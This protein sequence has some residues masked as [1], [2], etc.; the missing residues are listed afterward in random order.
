M[1]KM[2]GGRRPPHWDLVLAHMYAAFISCFDRDFLY[3]KEILEIKEKY[4]LFSFNNF[5]VFKILSK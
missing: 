3:F 5:F 1:I 2:G 4:D